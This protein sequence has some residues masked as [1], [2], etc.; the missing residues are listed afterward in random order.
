MNSDTSLFRFLPDASYLPVESEQIYK[1]EDEL[2]D[3]INGG[4][5]LYLNYGFLEMGKRIYT[6]ADTNEVKVEVFDMGE[7]KNAYGVFSYSKNEE[8]L[9]VGQGGQYTGGSL[10]FW[11]DRYFVSIF[12]KHETKESEKQVREA[13]EI[14]SEN[15]GTTGSLPSFFSIMPR[16]NLVKG[17]ELYFR[18]PAWQNRYRFISNDNI[19]NIDKNTDAILNQYGA[20]QERYYLLTVKYPDKKKAQKAYKKSTK[21]LAKDLRE[22]PVVK[23]DKDK[24]TGCKL[25]E[26]L[27]LLVFD[28]PSKEEA[29]FLMD[30][31]VNNYS[32]EIPLK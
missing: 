9:E 4:A 20:A 6:F 22:Q 19:F 16:R 23:N 21:E 18:N 2:Y 28:A 27:L 26:D 11:Q 30:R 3:Y 1:T 17:S 24:W 25:E 5:E 13:S 7:P 32:Q 8:N 31:A 15:I 29:V 12:A 14:I 10:I